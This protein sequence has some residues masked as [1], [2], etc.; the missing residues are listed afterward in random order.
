MAR[1]VR[2]WGVSFFRVPS[3]FDGPKK[4]RCGYRCERSEHRSDDWPHTDSAFP[5]VRDWHAL[6]RTEPWPVFATLAVRGSADMRNRGYQSM[7]RNQKSPLIPKVRKEDRERVMINVPADVSADAR[8]YA[9]YLCGDLSY[10]FTEAFRYIASRDGAFQEWRKTAKSQPASPAPEVPG[11]LVDRTP[12]L[13]SVT[14]A[15]HPEP[16][17]PGRKP[18]VA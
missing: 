8:L 9:E 17:A 2:G 10:V 11:V 13:P 6:L 16:S 15:Q 18:R 4:S 3:A 14:G 5:C 1:P 12:A 7:T